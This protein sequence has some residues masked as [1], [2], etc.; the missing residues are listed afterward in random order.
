MLIYFLN[1][2]LQDLNIAEDIAQDAFVDVYVY[3]ERYNGKTSFK[4]YLFTIGRNKAI[5]YIRKNKQMQYA[6]NIEEQTE[7]SSDEDELIDYII[8][9]ENKGLI[10]HTLER[11]KEEYA[12]VLI[13]IDFEDFSYKEAADVLGKTTSQVKVLVHRARKSLRKMLEEEGFTYE[14]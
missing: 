8:Q 13:L 3:K 6:V 7:I 2:Y 11:M 10:A 1:R 14:E 9:Q 5:D 12:R 4:T